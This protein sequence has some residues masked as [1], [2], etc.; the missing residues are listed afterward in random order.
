MI[1]REAGELPFLSIALAV[2][3]RWDDLKQVLDV[4]LP[5]LDKDVE[6]VISDNASP[7]GMADLCAARCAAYPNV[8]LIRQ[9]KNIDILPNFHAAIEA[10]EGQYVLCL[11]DDDVPTAHFVRFVKDTIRANQ[12]IGVFHFEPNPVPDRAL[13]CRVQRSGTPAILSIFAYSAMMAGLA[14]RRNL[15]QDAWWP[16]APDIYPQVLL[17]TAIARDNGSALATGPEGLTVG[18]QSDR[19][20]DRARRRPKDYGIGERLAHLARIV[21]DVPRMEHLRVMNH[22]VHDLIVWAWSVFEEM[23]QEDREQARTFMAALTAIDHV[24]T[25]PYM[26]L[27]WLRSL[28]RSPSSRRAL[29]YVLRAFLRGLTTARYWTALSHWNQIKMREAAP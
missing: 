9:P 2:Y 4:L 7:N 24:Y 22:G 10:C 26:V 21:H 29:P 25:S 19:A 3:Q 15:F 17:A 5:Q 14:F 1:N 6:L 20:V 11:C 16:P 8:R 18:G 12:G 13:S 23:W 27:T 28:R